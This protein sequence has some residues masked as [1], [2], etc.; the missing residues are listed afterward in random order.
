MNNKFL[1]YSS[2]TPE[3]GVSFILIDRTLDLCTPT[4]NNTE[5]FLAKILRTFPHL[6]HHDNDVAVNIAPVFGTVT[7]YIN[8]LLLG[9]PI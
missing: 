3:I 7:V 6:P 5:S 2:E 9:D 1:Q 8:S 4:S